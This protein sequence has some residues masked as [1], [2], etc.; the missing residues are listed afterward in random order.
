[1]NKIIIA[2]LFT[3]M[4]FTGFSS[5]IPPEVISR[6]N[7]ISIDL[8]HDLSDESLKPEMKNIAIL[9]RLGPSLKVEFSFTEEFYGKRTCSF[10]Y[11][12]DSVRFNRP[13]CD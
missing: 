1:M 2:S 12:M 4:S 8:M 11:Y 10:H 5:E 13:L 9:N 7:V 6:I 3:L